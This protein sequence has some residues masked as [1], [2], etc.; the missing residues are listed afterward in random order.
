M[1]GSVL[2][3]FPAAPRPECKAELESGIGQDMEPMNLL[4][5]GGLKVLLNSKRLPLRRFGR[6]SCGLLPLHGSE[7]PPLSVSLCEHVL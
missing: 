5:G 4:E 1:E 3:R 6:W 2:E 7:S